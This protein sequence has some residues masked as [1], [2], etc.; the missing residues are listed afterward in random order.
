MTAISIKNDVTTPTVQFQFR[1]EAY[2]CRS[3]RDFEF[4]SSGGGERR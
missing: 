2:V 1:Y 3:V 4:D